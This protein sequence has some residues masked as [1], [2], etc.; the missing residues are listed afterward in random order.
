M[1]GNTGH[2]GRVG[3]QAQAGNT[4]AC[5]GRAPWAVA[6]PV[7]STPLCL[8]CPRPSVSWTATVS[9][10]ASTPPPP[11]LVSFAGKG[12]KTPLKTH[13]RCTALF[14]P[15]LPTVYHFLNKSGSLPPSPHLELLDRVLQAAHHVEVGV[16]GLVAHIA[17]HKHL[18]G[19]QAQD[20]VGL[21]G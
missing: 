4:R 12:K 9:C 5:P 18:A 20:L 21:W 10:F 14:N 16:G 6:S 1:R 7:A 15:P 8:H 19:L 13:T 3:R 17:L 11:P 2:R